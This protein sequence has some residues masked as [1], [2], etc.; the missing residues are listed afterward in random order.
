VSA[1]FLDRD[2]VRLADQR[3]EGGGAVGARGEVAPAVT[4]G[5]AEAV[6]R[7][8]WESVGDRTL[9]VGVDAPNDAVDPGV[10]VA[11]QVVDVPV[12]HVVFAAG[13]PAVAVDAGEPP[14]AERAAGIRVDAGFESAVSE[15]TDL[16]RRRGRE[17]DEEGVGAA[18]VALGIAVDRVASV[19]PVSAPAYDSASGRSLAARRR[20]S[21]RSLAAS[22]SR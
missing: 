1:G 8:R 12:A 5:R 19:P 6:N 21:T 17:F 22:V 10:G 2:L 9:H 16:D 20:P 13:G 4:V 3:G 15:R 18:R 7:A 11:E 14:G